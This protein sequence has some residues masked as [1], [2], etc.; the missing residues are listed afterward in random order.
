MSDELKQVEGEAGGEGQQPAAPVATREQE[1]EDQLEAERALRA[2]TEEERD[3]A[4]R[5]IVAMKKGK[6]RDQ[7]SIEETQAPAQPAPV[8]PQAA[9]AQAPT[10]P[11]ADQTSVLA[12]E[13][14]ESRRREAELARALS[15]R[16]VAPTGG[17]GSAES[18]APKPKGYWSEEQKAVLK[19]RGW[20]NDKIARAE[21]TAR[22][23]SAT[24]PKHHEDVG[25]TKRPY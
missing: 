6:K 12:A 25:V 1:L 20:S 7:V 21:T 19:K 11:A 3:N 16:G 22:T 18:P 15:A 24:G 9:P 2:L 23:N 10:A 14:K 13:L 17:S 5:D 8:A 4:K